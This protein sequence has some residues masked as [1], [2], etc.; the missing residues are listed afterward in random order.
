M[1]LVACNHII[2]L[3]IAIFYGKGIHVYYSSILFKKI[4]AMYYTVGI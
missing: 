4:Q 2:K 1:E 3:M